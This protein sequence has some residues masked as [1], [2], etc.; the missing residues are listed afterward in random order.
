M[1][2]HLGKMSVADGCAGIFFLPAGEMKVFCII[3][4]KQL[5]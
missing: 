4:A 1:A 2:S 5:E 3:A